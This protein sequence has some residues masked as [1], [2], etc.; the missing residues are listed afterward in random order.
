MELSTIVI[1]F[2]VMYLFLGLAFAGLLLR[3]MALI[4]QDMQLLLKASSVQASHAK[5]SADSLEKAVKTV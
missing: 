1:I 4:R 2:L 3:F 5:R